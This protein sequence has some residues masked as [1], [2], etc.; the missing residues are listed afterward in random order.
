MVLAYSITNGIG[1]G[2]ISFVILDIIIYLIDKIRYAKGKIKDKP[3]LEITWVTLIVFI[4]FLV[5]FLV[6][7][8]I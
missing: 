2:I 3:K 7:T 6:P 4:L 8:I 1:V 5:Y